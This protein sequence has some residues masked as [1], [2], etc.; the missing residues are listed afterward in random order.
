ME[1]AVEGNIHVSFD[2]EKHNDVV[3]VIVAVFD[4][5]ADLGKSFRRTTI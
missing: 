3:D 5:V 1:F 2:V 4:F